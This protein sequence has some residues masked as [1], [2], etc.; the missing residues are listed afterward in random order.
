MSGWRLKSQPLLAP[1]PHPPAPPCPLLTL[2]SCT[3]S[4][5]LH[6]WHPSPPPPPPDSV[7]CPHPPPS[8]RSLATLTSST[9]SP[10]LCTHPPLRH[11]HASLPLPQS[12]PCFKTTAF[13]AHTHLLE[14]LALAPLHTH[15]PPPFAHLLS[16]ATITSPLQ[17]HFLLSSHPPLP[18]VA[19]G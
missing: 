10:L 6:Y 1:C 7:A 5:L 13:S 15:T 19:A 3:S 2:T 17:N 12:P 11:S 14:F 8:P 18:A 9:S 16:L 4:L